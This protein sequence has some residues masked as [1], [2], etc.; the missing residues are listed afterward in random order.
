MQNTKKEKL[1]KKAKTNKRK[2]TKH[3]HMHINNTHLLNVFLNLPKHT[4]YTHYIRKK[5]VIKK[6]NSYKLQVQKSLG[7]FGTLTHSLTQSRK[8]KN[9]FSEEKKPLK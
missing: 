2:P 3:K 6:E 4:H 9:E 8:Q 7:L 5:M 1:K